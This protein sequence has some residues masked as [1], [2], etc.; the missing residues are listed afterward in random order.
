MTIARQSKSKRTWPT[1]I[2]L[3]SGSGAVTSALKRRHFRVVASVDND[4]VAC[5][6]Y[7]LNHPRTRM[8]EGDINL[9]DP[10]QIGAA[11]L[12]KKPLDLLVVCAPCQPFSSQNRKR[13]EDHRSRLIL[14]AGRFAQA[15]KPKVIFFENVPGL[16]SQQELLEE[17]N[18]SLGK[19]YYLGRPE[20]I[21]AADYGVPQRRVRC[22]L[23]ATRGREPPK[24][25]EPTTPSH[26]RTTVKDAIGNLRRLQSGEGD[27]KDAMH[28]A[29]HHSEIVIERLAAIPKDG[30]SRASLPKELQLRCHKNIDVSKFPDVYGRMSWGDV[31]PTLTTGCTDVTRGRFAHPQDDRAITAREAALLQTFPRSYRFAGNSS[32]IQTQIGNAVPVRMMEAFAPTLRAALSKFNQ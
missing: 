11:V 3:F 31:A 5:A 4:P 26:S 22:I 24:L 16:V 13:G 1:A 19:D 21:D 2:D 28:V 25:P 30:G 12:G 32:D 14:Q 29:R 17:L 27:P 9:L 20:R 6:T 23:L 7:R 10:N 15:L 18:A 8:Y